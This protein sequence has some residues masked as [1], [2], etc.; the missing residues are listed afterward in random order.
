MCDLTLI[1]KGGNMKI[2]TAQLLFVGLLLTL[3]ADSGCTQSNKDHDAPP[4]V[5]PF[6]AKAL[7]EIIVVKPFRTGG[8]RRVDNPVD[9]WQNAWIGEAGKAV[10]TLKDMKLKARNEYLFRHDILSEDARNGDFSIVFTVKDTENQSAFGFTCGDYIQSWEL[11]SDFSLHLWAKLDAKEAKRPFTLHLYDVAGKKAS[12][13]LKALK[14]DNNWGEFNLALSEFKAEPGFNSKAVRTVQLEAQ[15][16]Q[17][18][19]VWLDDVYFHK[20]PEHIG[21]SDKT[22]T[23]YMSETKATLQKRRLAGLQTGMHG[24]YIPAMAAYFKG[25][26]QKA[27]D[28]FYKQLK[29]LMDPENL[30]TTTYNFNNA[31]DGNL[32]PSFYLALSSQGKVKPGSFSPEVE[33]LFLEAM[34]INDILGNDIMRTGMSTWWI[35]GSEN[36]DYANKTKSLLNSQIFMGLPDYAKRIYPNPGTKIGPQRPDMFAHWVGLPFYGIKG[37]GNYKDGQEYRAKEH[38]EA[39][40]KFWKEY[41]HERIKCGFFNE[42]SSNGYSSAQLK[43]IIELYNW[44]KDPELQSMAKMFNDVFWAQWLQDQVLLNQGGAVTRGHPGIGNMSRAARYYMGGDGFTANYNLLYSDYQWPRFLWEMALDRKARDEYEFVSRKPL[45][46][47]DLHPRPKG[48]ERLF[49][50][51]PDSRIIRYSWVTPDYIMGM[52]MDYPFAIYNHMGPLSGQGITF[53]TG[54]DATIFLRPG[55]L[56]QAVQDRNVAIMK[57]STYW[58]VQHPT[59]FPASKEVKKNADQPSMVNIGIGVDQVVEKDGWI[60]VQEADAYGAFRFAQP[61]PDNVIQGIRDKRGIVTTGLKPI[62]RDKLGYALLAANKDNY[63]LEKQKDGSWLLTAKDNEVPL[64]M[65]M[66]R[67][68]KHGNFEAF[69]KDV[70]DNSLILKMSSSFFGYHVTYKGCGK[71][72]KELYLNAEHNEPPKIDGEYFSY[73]PPSLQSPWLDAPFGSGVVTITAPISGKKTVYDFNQF[74]K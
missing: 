49:I 22:I 3:L 65:E 27:N 59:R 46:E 68:A 58:N 23:Q 18:A 51:R 54:V 73:E 72:A 30:K 7:E 1:K 60:F 26:T 31:Y 63:M 36:H 45:E 13:E 39:W 53:P 55:A 8:E 17:E 71:D 25:N 69:Q 35:D 16:P 33:K 56:Y 61:D 44:A 32:L 4:N 66:S 47:Q 6:D 9:P 5:L 38:Y 28:L 70:I 48:S 14:T 52:R 10:E 34:W 64:I 57:K 11:A 43:F 19:R 2:L 12:T 62:G 74:V 40:V 37:D 21:I 20:G 15:L 50:L 24:R 29:D 41:L 42:H 67:K